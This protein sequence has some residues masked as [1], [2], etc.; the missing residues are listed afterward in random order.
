MITAAQNLLQDF[1]EAGSREAIMLR[2]HHSGDHTMAALDDAYRIAGLVHLHRR[3]L[4]RS[5]A[6]PE[7]GMTVGS[8]METLAR[9]PRGGSAEVCCLFPLFT[10][11]CEVRDLALRQEIRNRVKS[12]E[13]AGMKQ[14]RRAR[15]LMERTWEE[16]LPWTDLANGEFLG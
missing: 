11:G 14:I 3:V 6:D 15:K 8:L 13:A 1:K 12:C 16:Q 9:I 5:S 4:G 10:A 2:S 7:V